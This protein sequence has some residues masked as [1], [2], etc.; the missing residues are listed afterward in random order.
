M[1]LGFNNTQL[2]GNIP[3]TV[4]NM[5]LLREII[6]GYN[7]LTGSIPVALTQ[8]PSLR[9]LILHGNQFTGEIPDTIGNLQ[10]LRT[11]SL[12]NNNFTGEI[13]DSVGTPTN[14]NNVFLSHNALTGSIPTSLGNL[15]LT[16]FQVANNQ[17]T[18]EIPDFVGQDGLYVLSLADN[19]LTGD[20]TSTQVS[21]S[22]FYIF[23]KGNCLNDPSNETLMTLNQ[24]PLLEVFNFLPQGTTEY[25][26][27]AP[28]IEAIHANLNG[29]DNINEADLSLFVS[30]FDTRGPEADLNDD[31]IVNAMDF[32]IFLQGYKNTSRGMGDYDKINQATQKLHTRSHGIPTLGKNGEREIPQ[33]FIK[34]YPMAINAPTVEEVLIEVGP[35]MNEA[36]EGTPVWAEHTEVVDSIEG[37][38]DQNG[39]VGPSDYRT[40][41]SQ[42][43]M[44]SKDLSADLN[45][46]GVVDRSDFDV[47]LAN[48]GRSAIR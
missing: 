4:A 28:G 12:G 19:Y 35:D 26:A 14:L 7:Q 8:L 24:S 37:D 36:I 1:K 48:Y 45:D 21:P 29:D 40:L 31:G 44:K 32:M 16:W 6:F 9:Y 22:V 39:H 5:Q 30:Q 25:C 38:I 10:S 41:L 42:Y 33:N 27:G 11:L 18:G 20:F 43:G 34:L 3:D 13:P 23:L 47:M 46:D 15:D 2:T 17:L